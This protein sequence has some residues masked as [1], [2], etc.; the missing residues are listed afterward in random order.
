MSELQLASFTSS[1]PL[2]F[3]LSPGHRDGVG[4]WCSAV[5]GSPSSGIGIGTRWEIWQFGAVFS[6]YCTSFV[7][8][9]KISCFQRWPFDIC[10]RFRRRVQTYKPWTYMS[11]S[12]FRP[13]IRAAQLNPTFVTCSVCF[14]LPRVGLL[15][16]IGKKNKQRGHST[17]IF[18]H[19][20]TKFNLSFHQNSRQAGK[21]CKRK[22]MQ[23]G[24]Q[25]AIYNPCR[26]Y[27]R[28]V[29]T[30]WVATDP[31]CDLYGNSGFFVG[32]PLEQSSFQC[33]AQ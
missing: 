10:C 28:L 6:R 26:A 3:S 21:Q 29:W 14:S 1:L 33:Q 25:L 13:G 27:T 11:P 22:G 32:F 31:A 15:P 5:L 12:H 9:L 30:W 20:V 18:W 17:C 16:H 23:D 19:P 24:F 4:R 8:F 7:A 2:R